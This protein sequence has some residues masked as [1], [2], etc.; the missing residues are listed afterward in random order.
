MIDNI[1]ILDTKV[2]SDNWYVLRKITYEYSKKDGT[3]LTQ[4]R[5]AYD[6]GN[7]ATILLYNREQ[8][9]VILTR[10]F[11]LPTFVNGNETGML[12][13]ACAGLLDKDNA[14]DCIRR[15]TEEETGYKITDVR[16]I[17]EAYMSPGS[18]TEILYFFIAEYS[19]EVKVTDGGGAEHEEENIEVLELDIDKTM[20]MIENGEIKDGKTIMLLQYIKLNSI[21]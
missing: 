18:V 21:L 4:S 20:K 1:K 17:F 6:R 13:E 8:K 7:G 15:E 12:I 10:Q 19:K 14:E 5:E 3:K 11:R 2:L 9:T 16:K